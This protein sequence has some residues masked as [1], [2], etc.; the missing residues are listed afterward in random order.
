[1]PRVLWVNRPERNADC[2]KPAQL[3]AAAESRLSVPETLITNDP[4]AVRPFADECGGRIVTKVLGG[5]VHTE[6]GKRGQL[7]TTRVPPERWDDPRIALTAH[8]FQRDHRQGVR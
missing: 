5:I 3:T 8:L 1:M 4:K 6:D 2:T 7:Y